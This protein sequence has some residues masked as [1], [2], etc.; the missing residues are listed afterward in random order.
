MRPSIGAA[1]WC[2]RAA[3]SRVHHR[4]VGSDGGLSVLH[5][6][7]GRPGRRARVLHR[8]PVGGQRGLQRGHRRA[9]RV[10]LLA[11]DQ[12]PLDQQPVALLLHLGVLGLGRVTLQVGLRLS[13]L[14]MP[15]GERG[16]GRALLGPVARQ[17]WPRSAGGWPRSGRGSMV[18]SSWP[19]LT[20]WPS[21]KCTRTIWPATCDFTPTVV[22][23]CTVPTVMTCRGTSF[24]SAVPA[25]TGTA[26]GAAGR[27]WAPAFGLSEQ[28]ASA[29]SAAT[30]SAP[31]T[32]A[33]LMG[34]PPWW[35]RRPA[36]PGP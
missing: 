2:R 12:L 34:E 14:G 28:P 21:A 20:S 4:L 5:H 17:R 30:S 19:C 36:L 26:G 18:N 31:A 29:V 10:V 33:R 1:I 35:P 9:H 13:D 3:A 15:L 32:A 27:A 8:R 6:G 7:L 24:C 22:Y 16:L 25:P 23:A 11:R